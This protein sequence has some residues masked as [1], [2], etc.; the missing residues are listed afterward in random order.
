MNKSELTPETYLKRLCEEAQSP[1]T[2]RYMLE[3]YGQEGVDWLLIVIVLSL[4]GMISMLLRAIYK[5]AP[6]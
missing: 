1:E 3:Q 6:K 2:C 4:A 5:V